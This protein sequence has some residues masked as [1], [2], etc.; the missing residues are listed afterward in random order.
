L[1]KAQYQVSKSSPGTELIT[2]QELVAIQ[3]IWY[4]DGIFNYQVSDIYNKIYSSNAMETDKIDNQ[5]RKE[6]EILSSV[7]TKN[8]DHIDLIGDLLTVQKTKILMR[9]KVGMSADIETQLERFLK[10]NTNTEPV[11]D[12]K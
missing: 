10:N 2:N 6:L 8:P 11:N 1:L 4:R 9:K 12:H 5:K 3:V 7:C